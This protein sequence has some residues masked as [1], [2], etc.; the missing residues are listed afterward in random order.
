MRF[1][2]KWQSINISVVNAIGFYDFKNK[3]ILKLKISIE[4]S[5]IDHKEKMVENCFHSNNTIVDPI[6]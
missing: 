5:E 2:N 6:S 4:I 3:I 1:S